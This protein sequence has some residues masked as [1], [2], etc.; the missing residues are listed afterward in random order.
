MI[1]SLISLF[2]A[3]DA[4]IIMFVNSKRINCFI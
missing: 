2:F 4:K 3:D 1:P